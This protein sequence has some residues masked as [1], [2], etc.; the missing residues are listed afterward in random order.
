MSSQRK[1]KLPRFV[2]FSGVDGAGKSTQINLLRA[3]LQADGL[4]VRVITFWDDVAVLTGLREM[5]GHRIFKGDKGVGTPEA[6]ISRRDKN[7]RSGFMTI[8][9]LFL[10]I[11]D[12]VSLRHTMSRELA[13]DADFVICDR[14]AYDELVNLTLHHWFIRAYVRLVIKL[15]P[16]PDISFLLDADPIQARARKP[17]YPL[18][19]LYICRESYLKLSEL[20]GGIVVIPPMPVC[21]VERQIVEQ[22]SLP[23]LQDTVGAAIAGRDDLR[24]S[25]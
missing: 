4:R 10:Y 3:R 2:S 15:V 13:S 17:E 22:L 12:A 16:R 9:R 5:T 20:A 19:F 24:V 6:P 7:V 1:R 21:D 11:A 8:V 18:D 23:E 14:Y 25:A